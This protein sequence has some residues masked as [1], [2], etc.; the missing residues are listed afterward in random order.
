MRAR[1]CALLTLAGGCWPYLPGGY[2]DYVSPENTRILGVGYYDEH[3]GGYWP[4]SQ[5]DSGEIW[6]GWLSDNRK[7]VKAIHIAAPEGVGCFDTEIDLREF[8]ELFE[9]PGASFVTVEG[10]DGDLELDYQADPG[11]LYTQV[12]ALPI[13]RYDLAG[14]HGDDAGN[15]IVNQFM[16]V[17]KPADVDGIKL[18]GDSP[19][20]IELSDLDFAWNSAEELAQYII[21]DVEL[22]DSDLELLQRVV[23]NAK[24]SKGGFEVP[25]S[26]W[27]ED[28]AAYGA[29]ISIA[30]ANEQ[31]VE[32][33]QR[34]LASRMLAMRRNI[35]FVYID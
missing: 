7:D 29:Y 2:D 24:F 14:F 20:A 19:E 30:T 34:D 10:P 21:V 9:D 31:W 1:L 33:G 27:T 26:L 17:P 11:I 28:A 13:G 12:D 4:D 16:R 8:Y 23:C 18:D 25:R 15:V 5:E 3:L 6:W 22:V 35:G 32:I